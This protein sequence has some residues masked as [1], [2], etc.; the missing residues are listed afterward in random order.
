[1]SKDRR[2]A[3]IG[4]GA[5]PTMSLVLIL[6]LLGIGYVVWQRSVVVVS[7]RHTATAGGPIEDL[8]V[9]SG[10]YKRWTPMVAPGAQ[11]REV[12]PADG[13]ELVVL[14]RLGAKRHQWQGEGAHPGE[15]IL[16]RVSTSGVAAQTR[17]RW[18][19]RIA[20]ELP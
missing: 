9:F 8:Y 12:L 7:V 3:E 5:W 2:R 1:M 10:A 16:L 14:L 6:V 15:R 4:R 11:V 17:C 20:E 18:P 19:C 13:G